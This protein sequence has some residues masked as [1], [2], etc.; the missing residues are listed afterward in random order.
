MFSESFSGWRCPACQNVAQDVPKQYNCFCGKVRDP[1]WNRF[2]TP[3]SCGD[4]CRKKR[5]D[6]CTHPCNM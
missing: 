4:L 5:A 1:D 3:H 2:E 6:Q